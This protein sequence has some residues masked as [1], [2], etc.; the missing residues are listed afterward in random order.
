MDIRAG[1]IKGF[2]AGVYTATVQVAGSLATWLRAVPVSRGIS[3]SEMIPGRRCAVV[4]FD[5]ANPADAVVVA[6][7]T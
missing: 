5:E 3:A 4:F 2:D 6:V 7:F 1:T